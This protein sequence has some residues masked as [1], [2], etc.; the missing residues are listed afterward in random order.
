MVDRSKHLHWL[1]LF[2]QLLDDEDGGSLRPEFRLDGTHLGPG[3]VS[4][5]E[6][7]LADAWVE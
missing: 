7:A 1:D 6:K 4:L 2:E 5:L 3:Y